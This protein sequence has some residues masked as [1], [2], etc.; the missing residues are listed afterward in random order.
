M[1]MDVSLMVVLSP[2]SSVLAQ[3]LA[4][5]THIENEAVGQVQGLYR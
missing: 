4:V 2:S 1:D 3:G 5:S